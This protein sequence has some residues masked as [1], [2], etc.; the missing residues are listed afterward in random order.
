MYT[1]NGPYKIIHNCNTPIVIYLQMPQFSCSQNLCYYPH[2]LS[3]Y[4]S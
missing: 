3:N 2:V 1:A 4:K